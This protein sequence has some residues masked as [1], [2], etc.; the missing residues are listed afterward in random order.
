MKIILLGP[1]GAGKGTQAELIRSALNIPHISTGDMLRAAIRKGDAFGASIEATVSS[2]KFISDETIITLV[3]NRIAEPDCSNGFILDGFPRTPVQ[4]EAL[5][6]A[7][8]AIDFVVQI[9]VPDDQIIKRLA[10][11]RIHNESGRTYNIYFHPPKQQGKDDVTGEELTQRADDNEAT[12]RDRLSVYHEKTEPLIAWYKQRA[13]DDGL[14]LILV[15][16]TQGEQKV[17]DEILARMKS[18]ISGL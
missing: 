6:E 10:G 18:T 12:V 9:Q 16:G 14:H 11:R 1:P 8:V 17:C 4:A 15:D 5:E 7:G 13:K 3:K 2:G